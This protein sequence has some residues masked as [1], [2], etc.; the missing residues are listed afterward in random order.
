MEVRNC[1]LKYSLKLKIPDKIIYT[2]NALIG[3]SSG[4]LKFI[5]CQ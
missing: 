1:W 5:G 4:F 3:E 2:K